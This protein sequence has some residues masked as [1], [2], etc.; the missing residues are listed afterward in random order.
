MGILDITGW[1][2]SR[3]F[4][5]EGMKRPRRK[6]LKLET[7][8]RGLDGA[9]I[10]VWL[11]EAL[12]GA[13]RGL[14]E[15]SLAKR[16][17]MLHISDTAALDS[18]EAT[19]RFQ[20]AYGT[21]AMAAA[22]RA[23]GE[24]R[25]EVYQ[26]F[27]LAVVKQVLLTLDR[28]LTLWGEGEEGGLD[29]GG[30]A[31]SARSISR[32]ER[33]RQ[34][35]RCQP[36]LRYLVAHDVLAIV[37]SLD[38]VA[39]KRRKSIL[40]L[41]W[42]VAEELLFNPLLQLGDL[43]CEDSFLELYPLVLQDPGRFREMDR[44]VLAPLGKWL[45]HHC[46]EQPPQLDAESMKS[47]PLRRDQGEL[48]GYARVEAYLRQVMVP[49]E[50]RER[51]IC[52]LDHPGNLVR[53]LGGEY[54][55]KTGRWRHPRWSVY[56]R[57]LLE[58]VE[59][60]LDREGLLE[61]LL[62]SVR[63]RR[64][65]PE[66][67]RRGSPALLL[68][69]LLGKRS[70]PELV[71][72]LDKLEEIPNLPAYQS[73]LS[74]ARKELQQADPA[75]RRRWLLQALEGYA[76]LRRDLKLAWEAYRAMDGFRLLESGEDLQLSRANGLLQ[77]FTPGATGAGVVRGH[78]IV[79][80]DLRGSTELIAEMN[81]A[82]V[83]PATYFT[84]NLFEPLNTLLKVF[85]AEKV[86]LEGDAAILIFNDSEEGA[87]P[88]VARACGFAQ[89]LIALVADR[90]RENRHQG[91][92]ELELGVGIAYEEG[93]P[94]YLF[95]EGRRITISPAIHRA[96]RLSSS[97]LPRDLPGLLP[98]DRT[99]GW[100]VEEVVV[101]ETAN[102]VSEAPVLRR[103]NVNGVELDTPAFDRL[104]REMA[105]KTVPAEKAGGGR[106]EYFHLGRFPDESGKTRWLVVRE[107]SVRTWDGKQ[108]IAREGDA[109]PRFYEV[110]ASPALARKIRHLLAGKT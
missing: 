4:L 96:D 5:L 71:S 91:L 66:L 11:G 98:N 13:I 70:R 61:P 97:D 60:N 52:W 95:D 86:F 83:N 42:P 31:G 104:M 10:D 39:R 54:K 6:R 12:E 44:A 64:L 78:V 18:G 41:S 72:A 85:A 56:Q 8:P 110:V 2:P 20:E 90:N 74:R 24:M 100:G 79:K 53:L 82:G 35:R 27:H 1:Q 3:E 108:L 73:A 34:F 68:D 106:G 94:T 93:A 69:Y 30:V 48:A 16:M 45:P 37:H 67:G 92:P 17:Q 81:R 62:A 65:Y 22:Q 102:P 19:R 101:R 58:E 50:Y 59:Q 75:K 28:Q 103:Y 40:A 15:I 51:L 63:L 26:L 109:G 49:G 55:G 84:H 38:R 47:L 77:D 7:F 80:A 46:V 29:R 87:G 25:R 9:R 32:A 33:L 88:L 89:E 105:L 21:A 76:A 36:R 107:A 14:V 57:A 43:E 99:D 23:R